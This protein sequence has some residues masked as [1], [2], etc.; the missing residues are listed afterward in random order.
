MPV[1]KKVA[2]ASPDAH[3]AIRARPSDQEVFRVRLFMETPRDR[4]W[5]NRWLEKRVGA[6]KKVDNDEY[7][8]S[9]EGTL[10]ALTEI[11]W[12]M[13]LANTGQDILD[14]IWASKEVQ[15]QNKKSRHN[16]H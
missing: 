4:K 16:K 12:R 2:I 14:K 9:I 8:I 1:K 3:L 6:A 5:I 7:Q 15:Y 11:P 13:F 10:T